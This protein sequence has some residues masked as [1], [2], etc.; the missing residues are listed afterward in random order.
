MTRPT[1]DWNDIPCRLKRHFGTIHCATPD[2]QLLD[3]IFTTTAASYFSDER[4]FT[5][6]VQQTVVRLVPLTRR[7]WHSTKVSLMYIHIHT[8][9]TT[10]TTT[11]TVGVREGRKHIN[12]I[13]IIILAPASTKPAG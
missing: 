3:Q 12:S 11:S 6:E 13:I 9:T 2:A 8:T 4:D 5:A 7:L 1:G 10:T